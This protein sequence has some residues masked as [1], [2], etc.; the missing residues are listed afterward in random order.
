MKKYLVL[1]LAFFIFKGVFGQIIHFYDNLNEG[2]EHWTFVN[3]EAQNKWVHGTNATAN[4]TGAL[5]VSDTNGAT[6]HYF[7]Y[8]GNR[9]HVY[10]TLH[11]FPAN[12]INIRLTFDAICG[13]YYSYDYMRVYL[14]PADFVPVPVV[15]CY[16]SFYWAADEDQ[17]GA[18]GHRDFWNANNGLSAS[19]WTPVTI[20]IPA[21]MAAGQTKRLQFTWRNT[22]N[23]LTNPPIGIDNVMITYEL[24]PEVP[25][26]S[27]CVSPTNGFGMVTAD[28]SFQWAH[29]YES[30]TPSGFKIRY[31]TTNPPPAD[32]EVNVGYVNFYTPPALLPS[33]TTIFWQVI[34]FN[35]FGD[36]ADCPV[37][38]F[39]TEPEGT[40]TIGSGTNNDNYGFPVTM[41]YNNSFC[42]SIYMSDEINT[43]NRI[44]T[45]IYYHYNGG[46]D[47]NAEN[48]RNWRI[49][50]GNT[51]KSTFTHNMDFIPLTEMVEVY[52][53]PVGFILGTAGWVDIE[54]DIPFVYEGENIVIAIYKTAYPEDGYNHTG[55]YNSFITANRTLLWNNDDTPPAFDD[56]NPIPVPSN[57]LPPHS[58]RSNTKL[59]FSEG[60][61]GAYISTPNNINYAVVNLNQ[62][63]SSPLEV[64]NVGDQ[65]LIINSFTTPEGVTVDSQTATIPAGESHTFTVTLSPT[66]LGVFTENLIINSNA[67]YT[68][69]RTVTINAE[70]YPEGMIIIGSG[71][72]F[73]YL[74]LP[75][76]FDH[77]NTYTQSIYTEEEMNTDN[78]VIT[79]IF[80]DYNG[81]DSIWDEQSRDWKIWM[82]VTTATEF[83]NS[84]DFLLLTEMVEVFDGRVDF[85]FGTP[86]WVQIN[87]DTPFVYN[88]D[89]LV[90]AV[91]KEIN[92]VWGGH[93]GSGFYASERG[94]RRTLR[95]FNNELVSPFDESNPIP[96]PSN[97]Y[98]PINMTPNIHILMTPVEPAPYVNVLNTLN[99][100]EVYINSTY[101]RPL[102]VR[103]SGSLPLVITSFTTPADIEINPLTATILPGESHTFT[104]TMSPTVEGAYNESLIIYS[105]AANAPQKEVNIQAIVYPEG[106]IIIGSGT[107]N[108]SRELPISMFD[109]NSYTQSIYLSE[110]ISTGNGMLTS[111]SYHFN[112]NNSINN[113]YSRNWKIWMGNTEATTMTHSLDFIPMSSL[114]Q[115]Y[116]GRVNFVIGTAGWVE[117]VLDYPFYYR[118]DNLVIAVY[119]RANPVS[120]G[121]YNAGF[122]ASQVSTNRSLGWHNGS[123]Q[124]FFDESNDIPVPFNIEHPMNYLANIQ[125]LITD[126]E[127]GVYYSLLG[128]LSYGNINQNSSLTKT[129]QLQNVGSLP[130]EVT[131][132]IAPAEV[133]V[134]PQTITIPANM[135]QYFN[136]TLSPTEIGA[137]SQTLTIN[138]NA[139]NS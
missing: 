83:A 114:E 53:G 94:V 80:Y 31:G 38:S 109:V 28:T 107:G 126:A 73:D 50:L 19:T 98:N 7:S 21:S 6:H 18:I 125:L 60:D 8:T 119:K 48:S 59:A 122:Y 34:P 66:V 61:P 130:L 49:W 36:A 26:P 134:S 14:K 3:G 96:V 69:A 13:G 97:A 10:T 12:A 110:E 54:L 47:P 55:F 127:P 132:F 121:N 87:L 89:N 85:V 120:Y 133:T 41:F 99:F 65:P 62:T 116:E 113:E 104:V 111:I 24:A 84:M 124:E 137:Y 25:F 95:W 4:T 27:T 17:V 115:V 90:I 51:Y 139:T 112:G 23:G 42:Q 82:G 117:I 123:L 20:N 108:S 136:L 88:G 118:G 71:T 63:Y 43:T 64:R 45:N 138:T 106:L 129:L 29:P 70:V 128:N 37:W 11:E 91:Y 52:H 81:A 105:N 58:I 100:Q 86:G 22:F 93:D 56:S 9:T 131:S 16:D 78:G 40:V 76:S 39:T 2:S 92:T 103:N 44:V 35:S 101:D 46:S 67:V 135:S 1:L 68:S 30:A 79:E 33:N 32:S 74:G 72:S 15:G 75:I 5:Y 102:T 57:P 77:R